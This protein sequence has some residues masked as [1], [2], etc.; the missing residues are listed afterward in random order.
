MSE[1]HD[2]ALNRIAATLAAFGVRFVIVGG[3]AL[4]IQNYDIGYRTDDI[5]M[6]IQATEDNFDALSAALKHL[7]AELRIDHHQHSPRGCRRLGVPWGMARPTGRSASPVSFRMVP[8]VAARKYQHLRMTRCACRPRHIFR[9]ALG[10]RSMALLLSI[11]WW[12]LSLS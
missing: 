3:Y 2:E 1:G 11:H 12:L 9:C 10:R 8:L 4:G 5:D 6:A 7:K